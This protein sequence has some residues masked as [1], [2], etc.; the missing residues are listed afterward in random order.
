MIIL[1]L[2][3]LIFQHSNIILYKIFCMTSLSYN[4]YAIC[5]VNLEH[6]AKT[7]RTN[8]HN[9]CQ[10]HLKRLL[11]TISQVC[12]SN[13]IPTAVFILETIFSRSCMW[14]V[15]RTHLKLDIRDADHSTST[16]CNISELY[17]TVMQY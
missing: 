17:C 5:K 2:K 13:K 12:D 9:D 16:S 6:F 8:Y 4:I 3:I 14:F 1:M 11:V 10:T 15:I 7:S